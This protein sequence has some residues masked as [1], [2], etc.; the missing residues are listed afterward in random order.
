[1]LEMLEYSHYQVSL[2]AYPPRSLN[3][4]GIN[5]FIRLFAVTSLS[6]LLAIRTDML[7]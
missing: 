1:M 5:G 4:K 2:P 6:T 7:F 3:G